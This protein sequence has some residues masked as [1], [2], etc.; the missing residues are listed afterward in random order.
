MAIYPS[1][2][3][4]LDSPRTDCYRATKR[5]CESHNIPFSLPRVS[6]KANRED[7]VRIAAEHGYVPCPEPWNAM[8]GVAVLRD[9]VLGRIAT[10]VVSHG[11][12]YTWQ[13]GERLQVC[14]RG[15]VFAGCLGEVLVLVKE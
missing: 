5:F 12:W 11:H 6:S 10:G 4:K 13:G 14:D 2:P 9:R 3:K 7:V 15:D 8:E 1:S